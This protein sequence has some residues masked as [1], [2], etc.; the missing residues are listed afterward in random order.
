MVYIEFRMKRSYLMKLEEKGHIRMNL[1]RWTR[2]GGY[3]GDDVGRKV[4]KS[5]SRER[6]DF[7]DSNLPISLPLLG[8]GDGTQ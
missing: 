4:G 7:I 1:V 8:W 3:G 5:M 2:T 6:R